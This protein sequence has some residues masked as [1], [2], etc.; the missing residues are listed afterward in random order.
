MSEWRLGS[1]KSPGTSPTGDGSQGDGKKPKQKR[2]QACVSCRRQKMKCK[3]SVH[4]DPPQCDRCRQSN[5]ECRFEVRANDK[6]WT[7]S[8]EDRLRRLENTLV[9]LMDVLQ[10][11][12]LWRPKSPSSTMSRQINDATSGMVSVLQNS[13]IGSSAEASPESL[14]GSSSGRAPKRVKMDSSSTGVMGQSQ[15]QMSSNENGQLDAAAAQS[16]IE[17]FDT[18]LARYLPILVFKYLPQ[19]DITVKQRSP[20]LYHSILSVASLYHP[21]YQDRHVEFRTQFVRSADSLDYGML[22]QASGSRNLDVVVDV[23]VALS[24]AGAWLGGEIGFRMSTIATNLAGTVLPDELNRLDPQ[25]DKTLK[26]KYGAI[27]LMTYIIEQ[28]L[29]IIHARPVDPSQ[30]VNNKRR[31]YFLAQFLASMLPSRGGHHN[32]DVA[33]LKITANVELCAIIL[34]LQLDLQR[35]IQQEVV[36]HW[37]NQLDKWLAEWMGRLTASLLP[38]SWKPVLLTFHFAKLFLN[39]QAGGLGHQSNSSGSFNMDANSRL[40]Y[41]KMAETSALDILGMLVRDHD[42]ERLIGVGPVFYPTIFIT[43]G[44]LIVRLISLMR[45]GHYN[46]DQDQA[47]KVLKG[48]YGVLTSKISSPVLPCYSSVQNLGN[49]IAKVE[50][51]TQVS[52]AP[53]QPPPQQHSQLESHFDSQ[54]STMGIPAP[55]VSTAPSSHTIS[56]QSQLSAPP[57]N[58]PSHASL[59]GSGPGQTSAVTATTTTTDSQPQFGVRNST[60]GLADYGN[61]D[62]ELSLNKLWSFTPFRT[63]ED[64]PT[65]ES[66]SN[67]SEQPIWQPTFEDADFMFD[68]HSS[69]LLDSLGVPY[70]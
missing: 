19:F 69:R 23:L 63:Y 62:D 60:A 68:A 61:G 43:A 35:E 24:M 66:I 17:H 41:N 70:S 33:E 40:K 26:E 14:A 67:D 7:S 37:N 28:R 36:V 13:R 48:A 58:E 50:S 15:S 53:A 29:R 47:L 65:L 56:V 34:M 22:A 30:L 2:P 46:F 52:M 32:M 12:N 39:S 16:L 38:S 18:K 10:N 3:F 9:E 27:G 59:A 64:D 57:T 25:Q 51:M 21:D 54:S 44:A 6:Q 45:M 1:N 8:V 5:T 4:T 49:G 55:M 20:V 42:T 31:D 11:N